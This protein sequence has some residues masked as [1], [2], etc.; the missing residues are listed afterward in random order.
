MSS[1][2][3]SSHQS[4]QNVDPAFK[5]EPP[6]DLGAPDHPVKDSEPIGPYFAGTVLGLVLLMLGGLG[7]LL[8][9]T[10]LQQPKLIDPRWGL[11]PS[12]VASN[13]NSPSNLVCS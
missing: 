3:D 8:A 6:E 13:G 10:V 9:I 11:D 1:P 5:P 12:G 4:N 7:Y 2:I